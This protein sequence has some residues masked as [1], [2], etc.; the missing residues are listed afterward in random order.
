[1]QKKEYYKIL[2]IKR[3]ATPEEI[4]LA[5]RELAKKYHPDRNPDDKAAEQKFKEIGEA[6]E[7]LS[8]PAKRR[9]YDLL[10]ANWNRFQQPGGGASPA[11]FDFS[12]FDFERELQ[13]IDVEEV[14]GERVGGFVKN[15]FKQFAGEGSPLKRAEMGKPR[16]QE[17][18]LTAKEAEE[19]TK[20]TL[21][22]GSKKIRLTFKPNLTDGQELRIKGWGYPGKNGGAAGPLLVTVRVR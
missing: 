18:W 19:G 12:D 1:M 21:Q 22:V 20:K 11:D 3:S 9:Q 14:F 4:K 6:Y 5:Y 7:T 16:R 10:G 13:N 2:G 15:V 17:V 8:D